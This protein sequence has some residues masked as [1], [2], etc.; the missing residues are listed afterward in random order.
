VWLD[1]LLLRSFELSFGSVRRST[2][3]PQTKSVPKPRRVAVLLESVA[4]AQA[5][6]PAGGSAANSSEQVGSARSAQAETVGSAAVQTCN[7]IEQPLRANGRRISP[8]FSGQAAGVCAASAIRQT[9]RAPRAF[10]SGG[11][12]ARLITVRSVVRVHK[13]PPRCQT[14]GPT[15]G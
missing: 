8:R 5:E 15:V 11:Q 3:I 14:F 4:N 13:G 10:S 6:L 2:Q 7:T 12:S 1:H 9:S